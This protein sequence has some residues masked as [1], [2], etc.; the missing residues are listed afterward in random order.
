MRLSFIAL[1][2]ATL[3]S[4]VQAQYFSDGW[5]PGQPVRRAGTGYATQ[6]TAT[7]VAGPSEQTAAVPKSPFDLTTYLELGPIKSLFS[8]AGVNITERLEAARSQEE[9]W[10]SRIPLI[11]DDNYKDVIEE[12]VFESLEEEKDRIW[13]LVMLVYM[14]F[15]SC[16]FSDFVSLNP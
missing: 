5:K 1:A 12:E 14:I 13:F 6:P 3:I 8:R 9:I 10:D 7:N 2:A 16:Y 4:A 15:H 11:T